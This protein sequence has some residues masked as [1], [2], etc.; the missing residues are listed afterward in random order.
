MAGRVSFFVSSRRDLEP[1][2]QSTRCLDTSPQHPSRGSW[3]CG[4]RPGVATLL[5]GGEGM[6]QEA[7]RVCSGEI[8]WALLRKGAVP[9]QNGEFSGQVSI[10]PGEPEGAGAPQSPASPQT[11]PCPS[12]GR[13]PQPWSR[14]GACLDAAP[15]S[16]PWK[17]S[18][19]PFTAHGRDR[20]ILV[21]SL[22]RS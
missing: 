16:G 18:L 2:L 5:P 19:P 4:I 12:L 14:A 6:G 21:G 22:V 3:E 8:T 17:L 10:W 15:A 20:P 11:T 7:P 1:S 9:S 13:P